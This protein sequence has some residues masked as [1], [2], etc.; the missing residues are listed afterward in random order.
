MLGIDDGVREILEANYRPPVGGGRWSV[1]KLATEGE[2]KEEGE[3]TTIHAGDCQNG[4]MTCSE[5]Y[6]EWQNGWC[7]TCLIELKGEGKR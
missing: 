5:N 6:H 4:C 7:S 3:M 2:N 1:A